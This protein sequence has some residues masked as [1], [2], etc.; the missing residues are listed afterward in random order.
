MPSAATPTHDR[1]MTGTRRAALIGLVVLAA[2]LAACG[3]PTE[4]TPEPTAT[5][6]AAEPTATPAATP[7]ATPSASPEPL[8]PPS[9]AWEEA[10]APE[11][12]MGSAT[13]AVV[14]VGDGLVAIGFD[15]AFGS[16]LWTS[17]DGG[18]TWKDVTPPDWV[19]VGIASVIEH[20]GRLVAVGR[21]N[22][23][24]VEAQQAAVYLSDDG[25]TWRSVGTAEQL[26]GQLID[27]VA[28]DDGLVAVGGVPGADAAGLWRSADGETWE[29]IG[30]HFPGAF[31]WSIAEGGPGLVVSG[32]RRNPDPDL[33]VWT[34]ADGGASWEL[35]PDPEG[36]AGFEGTDVAA[37]PDGTL[38]MV[39]SA[40]NGS[41]GR[42]WTSADGVTW[43]LALDDMAGAHARSLVLTPAGLVAVGGDEDMRGRAWFS[44]DA[45]TWAPLGD[46]VDEAYFT[47]AV[48]TPDGLL[49]TGAR[50]SGAIETGIDARARIWSATLGD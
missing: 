43:T 8:T 46:P 21:G 24:D 47:N 14:P 22:T 50:Q 49:V 39:G 25:V 23:M 15:G 26:V 16:I 9:L 33:A 1:R 11:A 35:A 19:S 2:V 5:P 12:P 17:A 41:G 30:G 40:F 6:T 7:A 13:I 3:T 28:T 32:W 10:A 4:P 48:A 29:R 38:A 27:V 18:A 34:S 20:D 42:I 37:L 44:A 36:F 31:M 45:V